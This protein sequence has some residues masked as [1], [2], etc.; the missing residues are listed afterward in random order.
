M[1]HEKTDISQNVGGGCVPRPSKTIER[2]RGS[3]APPSSA[4]PLLVLLWFVFRL[5]LFFCRRS[6]V[7]AEWLHLNFWWSLG[8]VPAWGWGWGV[9][10]NPE[11]WI[12]GGRRLGI[13][14]RTLPRCRTQRSSINARRS[15]ERCWETATVAVKMSP[16]EPPPPRPPP[17]QWPH[18]S[19]KW[20]LNGKPLLL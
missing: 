14:R 4:V 11:R 15:L 9:C 13:S 18:K 8:G 16:W 5:F 3:V 7:A 1:N 12:S 19:N 10:E 6:G 17:A 2:R 20:R